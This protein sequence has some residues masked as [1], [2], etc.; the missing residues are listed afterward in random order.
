[1]ITPETY[2]E[3]GPVFIQFKNK[4]VE[5]IRYLI[6]VEPLPHQTN[7]L[8][9]KDTQIFEKSCLGSYTILEQNKK[10]T[11]WQGFKPTYKQLESYDHL[12]AK[13]TGKSFK[14][15]YSNKLEDVLDD[16]RASIK[17]YS[18]EVK[19][20][21]THLK[22]STAIQSIF[23]IW[24]FCINNIKYKLEPEGEEILRTP[25]RSWADRFTGIDCDCFTILTSS[26]LKEMG[27]MPAFVVIAQNGDSTFTHIYTV[28]DSRLNGLGIV[29]GG[30][31]CDPV[32]STQ[33]NRHPENISKS[34]LMKVSNLDGLKGYKG[35]R[36]LNGFQA[37]DSVTDSLMKYQ[38]ELINKLKNKSLGSLGSSQEMKELRKARF[39]I[40]LQGSDERDDIL[41]LMKYVDDISP[42][43]FLIFPSQEM[44]E[45]AQQ[46][47]DELINAERE[48]ELEG[49]GELGKKKKKGNIFKKLAEGAKK[50]L[51]KVGGAI[52][53]V[54][55]GI[56]RFNPVTIAA[57]NGVLIAMKI[58]F[59]SL[60]RKLAFG[61]ETPSGA[62]SRGYSASDLT[63]GQAMVSK[64]EKIF[65][66]MGGK[67]ANLKSAIL[68]GKNKRPF[69]GGKNIG[70]I[71]GLESYL[72]SL[73]VE[74]AS[75]TTMLVAA[76]TVLAS[77]A[78]L[79]KN[80]GISFKKQ[81]TEEADDATEEAPEGFESEMSWQ[82]MGFNSAEE[83]EDFKKISEGGTPPSAGSMGTGTIENVSD[84][85]NFLKGALAISF[86]A[87][88]YPALYVP[89]QIGIIAA[90]I[91]AIR[92][93][94]HLLINYK[95]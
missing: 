35:V 29:E 25:A 30:T 74:P 33:F 77:L 5:A 76:G 79:V 93:K 10:H 70:Q 16:I 44:A 63:R 71:K 3:F 2:G 94:V 23:N 85:F 81:D 89:V 28:I 41:P 34:I 52:K 82:E 47:H 53:S 86:V 88:L 43:G 4:P 32:M 80:S 54:V 38:A 14:V 90:F 13:G 69:L 87:A 57:R 72:G 65:E 59:R 58:N 12:I 61:Y 31:V 84:L 66:K 20:L 36:G 9:N 78:K 27:F 48:A 95:F 91:W 62:S 22:A 39:M 73:G 64:F 7:D 24:H 1:M 51:K 40:M 60:A 68:Q 17:N 50:L 55:K 19:A 11:D 75:T 67:V 45:L 56:V 15:Y 46:Y 21:A 92:K 37:A 18:W 49:L 26:L 6:G 83:Y 8:S 42:E